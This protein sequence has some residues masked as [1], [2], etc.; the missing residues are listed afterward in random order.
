[1]A[2]LRIRIEL[3]RGGV[4]VPL[5]KLASVVEEAQK[6]FYLLAEDI[7]VDQTQGD[8]LGFD[9]GNESL[10]FTAEFVG[11]VTA[12]QVAAFHAAFD[13]TTS[14]RR[15]TIAQFARITESIEQDELIGFGLYMSD[16]G[17]EPT[18]WRCLSRRDAL[19]ITEE[20]QM[21]IEASGEGGSESHLPVVTNA[22]AGA[23]LFSD[24]RERGLEAAKW[25]AYV[26]EVEANMDRR[27]TRVENVIEGQSGMIED[28]HA[29]SASTEDS[30][31]KLLTA[32]EGFCAQTTRQLE[33]IS[34]PAQAQLSAP[35]VSETAVPEVTLFDAALPEAAQAATAAASAPSLVNAAA[36]PVVPE[37]AVIPT[38]AASPVI[39]IAK[40]PEP[41]PVAARVTAPPAP[42]SIPTASAW[43]AAVKPAP[44]SKRDWRFAAG[45]LLAGLG[46]VILVT[47]TWQSF[48]SEPAV[49]RVAATS[50]VTPSA[51]PAQPAEL[52]VPA[53]PTVTTVAPAPAGGRVN[54]QASELTW[55]SLRNAAGTPMLARVFNAGDT[56][57]FDMPNGATLRI[58]NAAGL[59]VSLNGTPLG[60]IGPHGQVRE[61]VFKNGSYKI[62]AAD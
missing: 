3:N 33:A 60:A 10:N 56:Q 12:E 19:R 26:R 35:E 40:E 5:H 14:L 55:V 34:A 50:S 20:I 42:K 41:V 1:M 13:G 28:L 46:V 8:W 25:A 47:W 49:Q 36:T 44:E 54:I 31:R 7:H 11:P 6:F 62:V 38:L 21:L 43:Q 39:E 16:E 58:G 51:Q 2:R 29:K 22:G 23:R 53:A 57:S 9:F 37:P 59:K 24:R 45:F 27:L 61:V 32:V 52:P 4:G 15:T 48:F 18:E 17:N 30:V